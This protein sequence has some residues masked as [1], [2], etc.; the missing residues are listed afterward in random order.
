MRLGDINSAKIGEDPVQHMIDCG[1]IVTKIKL[2]NITSGNESV[3][4]NEKSKPIEKLTMY[5]T[6]SG[7]KLGHLDEP[8]AIVGTSLGKYDENMTLASSE[9]DIHK[10]IHTKR[11]QKN[12]DLESSAC[13][14]GH[15]LHA[16]ALTMQYRGPGKEEIDI[17]KKY[18]TENL[19]G[20][21][22]VFISQ[23]GSGAADMT[24]NVPEILAN[25]RGIII[26]HHGA[27]GVGE[28]LEICLRYLADL[29][30]ASKK[31]ISDLTIPEKRKKIDNRVPDGWQNKY[32]VAGS[33]G[34]E[35][36]ETGEMI[37]DTIESYAKKDEDSKYYNEIFSEFRETGQDLADFEMDPYSRS[38]LSHRI[39]NSIYI[40]RAGV[41]FSSLEKKDIFVFKMGE[42]KEI[43]PGLCEGWVH[44]RIYEEMSTSYIAHLVPE[45]S[46]RYSIHCGDSIIPI[47]VE[48]QYINKRIPV[49][50]P[51]N[52]VLSEENVE[53]VVEALE[54]NE[55]VAY[56]RGLG[57]FSIS[58]SV[59]YETLHFLESAESSVRMIELAESI[60]VDVK[61]LQKKF[62]EW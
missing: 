60:G 56:I 3:V 52:S 47:D 39:G 14:H 4:V 59:L 19:G 27:F 38:A 43:K 23:Y 20:S 50:D 29:E 37:P 54:T 48:G 44:E 34:S 6:R 32:S 57:G 31:I 61:S 35:G 16:A 8:T 22:P 10:E 18:Q 24:E 5:I 21:V 58:Q 12:P 17:P 45:Y 40:T 41:D 25:N 36:P 46:T 13:L 28:D 1:K 42:G 2:N 11:L 30:D 7:S 55:K 26:G 33:S 49:A 51:G 9:A 15:T 53:S 62:E